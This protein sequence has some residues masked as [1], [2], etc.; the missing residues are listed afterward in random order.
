MDRDIA[1]CSAVIFRYILC[2]PNFSAGVT[3]FDLLTYQMKHLGAHLQ[4][5]TFGNR[6]MCFICSRSYTMTK[7]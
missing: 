4:S 7:V 1:L 3:T 5:L 2:G 6:N